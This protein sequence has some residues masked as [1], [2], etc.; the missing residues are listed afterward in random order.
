[1]TL[2]RT[3]DGGVSWSLVYQTRQRI[4]IQPDVQTGDC[5]WSMSQFTTALHGVAGLS[6]DKTASARIVRTD[7]GGRTWHRLTVPAFRRPPGTVLWSGVERLSVNKRRL[8]VR[9]SLYWRSTELHL[10][11]RRLPN[12]RWR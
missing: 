3:V 12:K 6:C 11:R 4:T 10:L 2:S 9:H 1:M 7:D 8:R 5:Q